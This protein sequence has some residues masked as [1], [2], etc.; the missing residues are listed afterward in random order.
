VLS[1]CGGIYHRWAINVAYGAFQNTF[2][3]RR[4]AEGMVSEGPR[5]GIINRYGTCTTNGPEGVR[6]IA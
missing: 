4:I 5:D 1:R 3:F 2:K 6:E